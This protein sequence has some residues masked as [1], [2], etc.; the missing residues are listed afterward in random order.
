M[1]V[2]P[3]AGASRRFIQEDYEI[4]KYML[5]AHGESVFEWAVKSFEKYFSTDTFIFVA[6][7]EEAIETFIHNRIAKLKIKN[8]KVIFLD[9]LT[10]GQAETVYKGIIKSNIITN[11]ALYIFNIDTVMLDFNKDSNLEKY[12]GY[13][14]VF[15]SEGTSWSFAVP[16]D[17]NSNIP[18][19][20]ETREKIR[21]S[22]LCSNGLYYFKTAQLFVDT[23][24]K[25]K[26]IPL[27]ELDG[28]ERYVAP[29][30]NYLIQD[31]MDVCYKIV[32]KEDHVF[33]GIPSEY[34][35]FKKLTNFPI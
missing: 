8:Y 21:V 28:N 25:I 5:E 1:I 6:M 3:M 14:E 15:E 30:Y 9:K 26:Q 35:N 4:P 24:E 23:Y 2:I 32:N 22:N 16:K 33:S 13:L 10:S 18:L 12:S 27:E 31:G 17:T 34:E 29:M 7:H 11:E 20:A 19:V